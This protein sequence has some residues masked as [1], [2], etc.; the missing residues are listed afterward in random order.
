MNQDL[1]IY[2]YALLLIVIILLLAPP[3]LVALLEID[4]N[5][6]DRNSTI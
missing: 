5:L 6:N 4:G 3:F 2:F 1:L